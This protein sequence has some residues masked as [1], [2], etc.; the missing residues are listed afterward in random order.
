L[1][2]L[3]LQALADSGVLLAVASKNDAALV[4]ETFARLDLLIAANKIFPFEVSWGP[5]S[6]AVN[7]VLEAWNIS[8]DSIVF[9]D[10]NAMELAEVKARHPEA[11]C[12]L[13]PAY[14]PQAVLALLARLR[15][16]FGKGAPSKED[17]LRLETLRAGAMARKEVEAGGLSEFLRRAEAELSLSF[18]KDALDPR[19]VELINKTNQFNLNSRRIAESEWRARL[20]SP[21][22]F[23]MTAS[24]RDKY[25]PLGKIG[26][27]T[28]G[29]AG[30]RTLRV[31][32][33]VMSCRAFAR[34]IEYRCLAELYDEFNVDRIAFCFLPTERN[35]PL[36][37]FFCELLGER[38]RGPFYVSHEQFRSKC[39]VLFHKVSRSE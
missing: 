8:A 19:P 15:N 26:V 39:P 2:Q 30:D 27:I 14:D 20:E 6:E 3:V 22:T 23:V 4:Q 31:D 29:L 18:A 7:R 37:D 24:Y 25:G 32:A 38:P 33:W 28:G 35:G 1:Y 13:F 10:D 16:L 34:H 11:E 21:D 12:L 36:Q 5:K 9:V 17:A